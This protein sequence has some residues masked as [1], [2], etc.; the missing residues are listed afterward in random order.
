VFAEF[1]RLKYVHLDI[2]AFRIK[3]KPGKPQS[4]APTSLNQAPPNGSHDPLSGDVGK[5]LVIGT[6]GCKRSICGKPGNIF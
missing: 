4:R 2:L 5:L 1:K 3:N 6:P